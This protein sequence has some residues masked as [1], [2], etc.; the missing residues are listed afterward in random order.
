M[1]KFSLLFLALFI[2]GSLISCDTDDDAH[3]HESDAV[4]LNLAYNVGGQDFAYGNTYDV[5][6]TA[7]SFDFAQFYMSG[8]SIVDDKGNMTMLEDAYVL[9]KPSQTDYVLV[10]F[11]GEHIHMFNFNVGIDEAT[12]NQSTED[13]TAYPA[14]SPLALQSPESMHW[15]WN[16]GYIF[17]KINAMVDTDGDGTPETATEYHIGTDNL[18]TPVSV[19][20]HEDT[21]HDHEDEKMIGLNFDIAQLFNGLDLSTGASTHTGDNIEMAQAIVANYGS[22]FSKQ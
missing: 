2:V 6:G 5:G 13:F 22:A 21:G 1:N 12:N 16:V 15:S 3:S 14:D 20:V 17:L 9:A 4:S 8:F 19:M 7:I 10:D 11:E 18:L